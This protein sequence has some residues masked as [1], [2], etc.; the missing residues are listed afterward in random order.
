MEY[1]GFRQ[2]GEENE[3]PLL[4]TIDKPQIPERLETMAQR[5]L[6]SSLAS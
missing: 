6:V 2:E 5:S 1:K 3:N 4:F